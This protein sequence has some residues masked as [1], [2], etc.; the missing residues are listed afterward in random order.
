MTRAK[1]ELIVSYAS[2][3]MLY[4]GVQHNPPSRFLADFDG[5]M[6]IEN[7]F[8][9]G[10]QSKF[11]QQETFDD[12]A[13]THPSY[14]DEPRYIP[15]LN[16]GDSVKH[17]VFGAGTVLEIDGDNVIIYFKGKGTKKLNVAFAP[18]EKL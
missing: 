5:K 6:Q 9:S 4:G 8:L 2:G 17:Q 3:R 10:L 14:D 18:L 12:S 13:Q 1:E 15:E 7:S 16:E 11:G